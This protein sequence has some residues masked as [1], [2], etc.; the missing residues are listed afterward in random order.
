[1]HLGNWWEPLDDWFG[2][3]DLAIANPPYI[4]KNSFEKLDSI[5]I[6]HEPH[7]AL[8]GGNDGLDCCRAIIQG[9]LNMIR[10]GGWLILE[11]NCDQS[12]R[13]L[14]ILKKNGFDEIE[15]ANDLEG[16]RRFALGRYPK[17]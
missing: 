10:S 6:N 17:K 9:S 15:F 13:V 2:Q 1:M 7:L 5:V 12:E 11:H 16:I 14:R 4:P 8:F 3:F